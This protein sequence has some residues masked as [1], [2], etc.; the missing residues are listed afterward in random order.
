MAKKGLAYTLNL[1]RKL[2]THPVFDVRLL[3]PYHDPLVVDHEELAPQMEALPQSD[4]SASPQSASSNGEGGTRPF[5]GVCRGARSS[6]SGLPALETQSE[7]LTIE[8]K[9]SAFEPKFAGGP[10]RAMRAMVYGFAA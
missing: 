4:A 5:E 9:R 3:K 6:R 10:W 2:R 1:P 8:Q 7:Q